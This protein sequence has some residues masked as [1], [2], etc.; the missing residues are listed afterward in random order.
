MIA[1]DSPA[2]V[3]ARRCAANSSSVASTAAQQS[4]LALQVSEPSP[5]S[6]A[7]NRSARPDRRRHRHAVAQALAQHDDIRLDAVGLEGEQVAGPAEV[8][9]DFIEDEDDVVS[10][11]RNACSSC[12]YAF[13]G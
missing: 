10:R 5:Y 9:L 8:R 11:G 7:A 3:R 4:G 6:S 1:E 2:D 12:R 13:G